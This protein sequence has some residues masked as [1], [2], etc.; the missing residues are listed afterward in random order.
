L[1]FGIAG[2]GFDGI[3][4]RVTQQRTETNTGKCGQICGDV[5]ISFKRLIYME[6]FRSPLASRWVVAKRGATKLEAA[7]ETLRDI[8]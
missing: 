2:D 4:S 7:G 6:Y 1:R 5:D 3:G 8:F